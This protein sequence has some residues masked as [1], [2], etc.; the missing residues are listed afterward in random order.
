[1]NFDRLLFNEQ[2]AIGRTCEII[3]LNTLQSLTSDYT[4]TDV[5]NDPSCYH[6]GDI[7]ADG[8]NGTFYLDVKNMCHESRIFIEVEQFRNGAWREGWIHR[9]YDYLIECNKKTKKLYIIDFKIL[10][11]IYARFPIGRMDQMD[12]ITD[13]CY[14]SISELEKNG[15]LKAIIDF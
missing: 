5:S 7:R 8:A 3:A 14:I 13:Y 4:F 9:S 6:K 12:N 1:M 2:L 10:K 15:A 11:E